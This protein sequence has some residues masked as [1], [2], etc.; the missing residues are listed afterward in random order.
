MK[1]NRVIIGLIG[2]GNI[3]S[4]FYNNLEKNKKKI[5]N[6]TGKNP[7]I[8][9]ISAKNINKKRKVKIPRKKWIKN[10][11]NLIKKTDLD[12]VVELV[13][14]SDGIAKKIVLTW[15][16]ITLIAMSTFS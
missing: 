15:S 13:G 16:L 8:K 5:F 1:S 6:K 12:V 3:G 9:Y 7:F 11:I 14:G 10:P 4:Y 2:F